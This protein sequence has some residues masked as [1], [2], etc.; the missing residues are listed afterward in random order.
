[1]FG[2]IPTGSGERV[3]ATIRP[4]L[5]QPNAELVRRQLDT[6]ADA[7]GRQFP[8]VRQILLHAKDDPTAFAAFSTMRDEREQFD[9]ARRHLPEG[10]TDSIHTNHDAAALPTATPP[11][12]T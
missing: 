12:G 9:F 4:I 6:V 5:A 2:V 7:L 3:A 8:K 10:S 11:Q 1:M